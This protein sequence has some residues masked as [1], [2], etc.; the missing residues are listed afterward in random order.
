MS[1]QQAPQM[2]LPN[3]NRNTHKTD[4]LGLFANHK[5]AANLL[6]VILIIAGI[7][8]LTRLN[9]QFFP[10]FELEYIQVR[11][12]WIGASPEDIEDGITNPLELS[13][14]T[15]NGVKKMSS[16]SATGISVLTLEYEE[17]TDMGGALDQVTEKIRSV[18]N[19]PV[20]AQKTDVVRL[21]RREPI[22]RVVLVGSTD[23]PE[24]RPLARRAE[25]EMLA[26]GIDEVQ[27]TGLPKQEIAIQIPQQRLLELG[28]TLEEVGRRIALRS[29]DRPAGLVGRD[30]VARQLRTLEQRRDELGFGQLLLQADAQG[31]RLLLGDIANIEQRPM[32]GEVTVSFEGRPAVELQALRD[33]AGDSLKAADILEEW[34]KD[35]RPRL[36]PGV[37][38]VVFDQSWELLRG[39]IDLLLKNGL[40]GLL[41]VVA[42]LFLFLNGRVAFWVAVGIPVSFMATLGILFLVGGTINMISLFGMI[43][44]LGIIVDDTIVV[45]E[46]ALSHY[47]TGEDPLQ[48]AEG[49]A[50]RMFAPVV[51]SSLTTVAAFVPLLTVGGIMGSILFDIPLV[52]ICVIIASL[53]ECFLVLPGHLQHSFR[54]LGHV[55]PSGFRKRFDEGFLRFR[56]NRFRPLLRAALRN[57]LLTLAMVISSMILAIGLLAGGRVGFSFFPGI[58]GNIIN[59]NVAFV[60]GTPRV[61]VDAFMTHLKDTLK[62]TD[63]ELGGGLVKAALVRH[64]L[65]QF[66][67][68]RSSIK[69]QQLASIFIELVPSDHRSVRNE[70]LI[71][72]WRKRVIQ[73]PGVERFTVASRKGGPPGRDVEVRLFNAVPDVLK[74]ASLDLQQALSAIDGVSAIED[75]MPYG[76]QQLIFKLTPRGEALGL[77]ADEVGRQLRAAFDGYL[78]EI[79]TVGADEFEVR[80]GLPQKQRDRLTILEDLNIML[81]GGEAVALGSVV[82]LRSQQGFDVLR[83]TDAA[84]TVNIY[85]DVNAHVTKDTIVREQLANDT[86]PELAD[87]YNLEYSFEG[88][89]A[90]QR[91][92]GRDMLIGALYAVVMI[93]IVLAW[94]FG[95]YGWPLVV[96]VAIPFGLVGAIVGHWVLGIDL[97]ILSMFGFFG[98]SGIVVNDSIILVVF[99]RQLR[100]SG[101]A[102]KEA[103]EQAAA[104][105]L[106]AV[107]L[108]SLT[109]IA[110]LTPLLF[111]TSLQAQFLIPMAVTI[112]FGLAFATLLVLFVVPVIL[113]L[114]EALFVGDGPEYVDIRDIADIDA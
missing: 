80:V 85:A 81:P 105:R 72:E 47:Q 53:I 22:A 2:R 52:V 76:P 38:L 93:Y 68:G 15:I 108:T 79:F 65:G 113:S 51:S 39:R 112:S 1:D 103:I 63:E 86:L 67:D 48:A 111:E 29:Q 46:D 89:A 96:M 61:R 21:Y 4:L 19:L 30:D 23:L 58:E 59:T 36:P 43:M 42:I 40:G 99:Y 17:G 88:R 55:K 95:S 8:A 50:R 12:V 41:L 82:T 104:L 16:T 44:A 9:A 97:T 70:T 13:L 110:G 109:T 28:L 107:L 102:I 78:A 11:T 27:I 91:E 37:D 56:D 26:R 3:G 6:M 10:N 49:G 45:G 66:A 90:D 32:D 57:R 35:A 101:M 24:L 31:Q 87:R 74:Q 7:F 75:D 73:P 33:Q 100:E 84:R 77:T 14:R 69:G 5:V 60:A 98:L 83:H 20:E 25:Q 114:Y 54:K 94:V 34:V 18:R 71:E 106:R 92:T 62:Q 64:N